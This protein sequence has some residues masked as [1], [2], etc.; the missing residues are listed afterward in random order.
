MS[1]QIDVSHRE[2]QRRALRNRGKPRKK[3]PV[4][5]A[6]HGDASSA[7]RG[8]TLLN[9]AVPSPPAASG[10]APKNSRRWLIWPLVL[11]QVALLVAVVILL[12]TP[13]PE[14]PQMPDREMREVR[15]QIRGQDDSAESVAYGEEISLPDSVDVEGYTFL[16]WEASDGRLETHPSSPVYRNLVFSAR[17][18]PSFETKKH[19]PYLSTDAEAVLDVDG[20]ITMREF[21]SIL[22]LLLD[23][24]ETG[25]GRFVDVPE[26]DSCYEAAAYLKD[27][28]IFS[29]NKLHPDSNL[30]CGEL[31][32]TLCL[33]FP[34]VDDEPFVF[35]D[36]D[37]DSP[38]YSCFCTAASYG[39]I[40]SGTLVRADAT[41]DISRGR[42]ARIMNHVLQRDAVRH[43]DQED[44]G[45]IL[46]VPPS[47]DYYG[48]VVEAVIPH[49]YRIRDGEE[50]W[51]SSEALPVHEP[52]FFFAGVRLHHIDE[53]GVPAVN[54]NVGGLD[55]NR[56]GEVTS[57]D[58][59]L[60][61]ELWKIL[62]DTI[63][64][65]EMD[66]EEMLRA[67]YDHVVSSYS[68]RYGSM[69]AFGAEGWAVREA[70][71]ML[72]Y[73]SGNCY[74]FAALFYEL[75]RFVGYDAKL[76]SGRAYG[77]Q[78]EYRAYD[79][80]LIYA[81]MGYTPH[82]WVEIEFDGEPYIFDTEYEY[83]SWGLRQM[84][85]GNEDIRKQYGY[86]KAES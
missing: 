46:D 82:G 83:R 2:R 61:R 35:Q 10:T 28:G 51:T 62:E 5:P 8:N 79:G 45:T 37:A 69:Y 22:Y 25:S 63:D 19:I 54:C 72:E 75:A 85:K 39:W 42:F 30:S 12:R 36:L 74:C 80:D 34:S 50:L 68:Y 1:S 23:T 67:V 70:K 14:L 18:I 71:R 9:S 56:N 11:L 77:E 86:T 53:D 47:G 29:G 76:Y 27:L 31:L 6:V 81:P 24:D 64:P 49:E 57:G 41:G 32:E 15:F 3:I 59:W 43:L 73:G 21:A 7:S 84:F 78:Y 4:R 52:G 38:Y 16:G 33:F 66:R 58:T 17:L 65:E 13:K 40:P 55:Y 48:D 20:P 60:D 26:D 44:V